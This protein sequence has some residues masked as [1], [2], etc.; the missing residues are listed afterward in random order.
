MFLP[1]KID[2]S[3]KADYNNSQAIIEKFV[4]E[5]RKNKFKIG[6]EGK[7]NIVIERTDFSMKM[8]FE[9][10]VL[11]EFIDDSLNVSIKITQNRTLA[12]GGIIS[13]V[14]C[15]S[16]LISDL[17]YSTKI[18]HFLLINGF[19]YFIYRININFRKGNIAGFQK[20][21]Q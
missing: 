5:L 20:V 18:I 16:I 3:I 6:R 12:M 19:L 11:F 21:M 10:R 13:L 15:I 8:P 1:F 4:S 7:F 9:G 2:Y 14:I 17:S